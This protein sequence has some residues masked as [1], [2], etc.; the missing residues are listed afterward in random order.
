MFTFIQKL[1]STSSQ[2]TLKR[3]NPYVKQINQAYE[4]LKSLSHDELRYQTY[5]LKEEIKKETAKE[6]DAILQ[7]K[8]EAS[9]QDGLTATTQIFSQ[10]DK[11]EVKYKAKLSKALNNVLPKAFAIVKETT[12]RF[13]ENESLYVKATEYDRV[14]A[15]R[16]AHVEIVGNQACWHNQWL[17]GGQKVTWDMVPYDVQLM[18]GIILHQGKIAEMAT[19]EGKTLAAILPAYLNALAGKGVHVITVNDYL[20]QR[21][22]EWVGPIYQ[23][24][25]LKVDC[26]DKYDSRSEARRVAY[27]ADITYGTNNEFGFD[28]LRDNMATTIKEKVQPPHHYAIVDE[29]DSVLI[30]DAR[31]P[32][33]ISGPASYNDTAYY[34]LF[35]SRV[36][37]LY[38]AQ[39]ELIVGLL[40]EAKEKIKA[41]KTQEAGLALLRIYRGLPKHEPFIQYL[42]EKGMKKLLAD[43]ESEYLEENSRKMPEADELLFFTIEEKENTIELTEKGLAHLTKQEEE[44]DFF[45][46]QDIATEMALIANSDQLSHEEKIGQRSALIEDYSKKSSRIHAIH[47]LLKG[48]TLFRKDI[49]YVVINQEVK[50]VDEKTGRILMGRRYSDGLHQALEAKENVK[51]EDPSQTYATITLQNY[52]RMYNKLA[53]MTGTAETE[54]K[55]LW[56]IYNLEVVVIPTHRPVSREDR[57]DKIFKT[58]EEKLE[59]IKE[60]VENLRHTGRPILIGTSTVEESEKV[61]KKLKVNPA[62]IL[63]A[64]NHKKESQIIA[65]AGQEGVVTVVT[66]MAGRG[67]DIK[68]SPAAKE[69]GGLAIIGAER[70]ENRRVDRQLRGRAGRQGDPGSS[71][72]F[73]S[74]EDNLMMHFKHG[75][76]GSRVDSIFTKKGEAI[77]D[78][79]ITLAIENAQKRLEENQFAYRKRALEYDDVMNMQRSVIYK[80]RDH[81]LHGDRLNLDIMHMLHYTITQIVTKAQQEGHDYKSFELDVIDILKINSLISEKEFANAPAERLIN[82]IYKEAYQFYIKKKQKNQ[83]FFANFKFVEDGRELKRNSELPFIFKSENTQSESIH[84]MINAWEAIESKGKTAM[85]SIESSIVLHYIDK[86][87]KHHLQNMDE[88]KAS[89]HNAR[90]ENK[91]PLLVYKFEALKLFKQLMNEINKE[92]VGLLYDIDLT[93]TTIVQ[94]DRWEKAKPSYLKESKQDDENAEALSGNITNSPIQSEKVASRNQ[95]VTVKYTDGTIK[96]NVK[97]KSIQDDYENKRCVII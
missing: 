50:I 90:Y 59:A 77:Q 84:T 97:F 14:L 56:D 44:A 47:Q 58:E 20:S 51:I 32:L 87:W 89:T 26:I 34:Y 16:Y 70:H 35:K 76:I 45:V 71:Q 28:Y 53:G 24:H 15:E 23:F 6:Y 93:D 4:K 1:F 11:L 22:A 38:S 67:T 82:T 64:K 42:S 3:L 33:I 25:G 46:L 66:H 2:K 74:L 48:Y 55:E 62:Q 78:R 43:T 49:D 54:A 81:A 68:L 52:F 86:H 94:E 30:D 18:G 31:T 65:R 13:K 57:N 85:Q 29:V 27:L 39:H 63:N 69:A 92:V 19:G 40:K 41:N 21:D 9:N 7:L 73:I 17:A 10:L 60:E 36:Q 75:V 12:R 91:D 72:F 95:R 88:L 5:L 83:D 61:G 8:G 80:K 37:Q 79:Y 96:E